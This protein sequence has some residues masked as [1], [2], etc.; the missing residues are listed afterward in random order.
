MK[1]LGKR[2][3]FFKIPYA[4]G[5]VCFYLWQVIKSNLRVAYNV[6]MPV[7]YIK[8]GIVALPLDIKKDAEIMLLANLITFTP[9]TLS[10]DVSDNKKFLY[11]HSIYIDDPDA[12]KQEI[13]HGFERR[14]RKL[15]R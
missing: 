6:V 10:V 11:V 13:K 1:I 9:G 2:G 8:P 5:F 15:F 4:A 14:I 12:L 3:L 7:R